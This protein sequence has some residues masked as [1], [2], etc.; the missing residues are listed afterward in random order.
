VGDRA[1]ITRAR[2]LYGRL[3]RGWYLACHGLV[4]TATGQSGRGAG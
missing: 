4:P 1:V 3:V 2:V